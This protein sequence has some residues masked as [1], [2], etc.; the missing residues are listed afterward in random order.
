LKTI[1]RHIPTT[2]YVC[3]ICK[4]EFPNQAAA[5]ACEDLHAERNCKHNEVSYYVDGDEAWYIYKACS[6]CLIDLDVVG[7]NNLSD[8]T[9]QSDLRLIYDLINSNSP[10]DEH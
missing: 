10:K 7:L 4:K 5:K 9:S 1:T 3:D 6:T 2:L 8:E